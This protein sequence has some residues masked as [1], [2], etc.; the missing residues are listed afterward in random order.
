MATDQE[1]W[2]PLFV[3]SV[4]GGS[5]RNNR[6]INA[7]ATRLAQAVKGLVWES[8]VDET[9]VDVVFHVTGPL[10]TPEYVGI[11]TGRFSKAERLIQVQVAVPVTLEELSEDDALRSLSEYLLEATEL[12]KAAVARR[13]GAPPINQAVRLAQQALEFLMNGRP[14]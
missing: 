8:V 10:M 5:T 11:R 14:E 9:G 3:G 1:A 12:A 13:K 2:S 4:I 7:A 6:A